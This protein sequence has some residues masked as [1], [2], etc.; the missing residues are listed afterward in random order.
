MVMVVL[1]G[2]VLAGCYGA[3]GADGDDMAS[4][5]ACT[6]GVPLAAAIPLASVIETATVA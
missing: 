2:M 1:G 3:G 5:T 4:N 6:Q